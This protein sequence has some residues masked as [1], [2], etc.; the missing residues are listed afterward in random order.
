MQRNFEDVSDTVLLE[1][2]KRR[3]DQKNS[4]LEEMEFLTKKLYVLNEKLKEHDSIKG[5][6]L[7]L[8]KNVFNNPLSSLLNLSS[9]MRK[10]EDS[11]KTQTMKLLLDMELRKLDFQL[12]NI[13]T[14]AE[15]EA[16]EIANY[17]SEID[18]RLII[19]EVKESFA[20]LIEEKELHFSSD[21][22][23]DRLIVSDA[24]KLHTIFA[25]LISNA[26]EYSFATH[27]VRISARI[28]EDQLLI[29]IANTGDVI[30]KDPNKELFSRFKK[31]GVHENKARTSIDG[32]GLGLSI[33]NAL[34]ESLDGE[35]TY[36]SN[37]NLTQFNLRLKLQDTSKAEALMSESANEFMFDDTQ[38]MKEF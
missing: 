38:E 5:E 35:I 29:S 24:K 32:L 25:N 3:F 16:G 17:W 13:F 2:V 26:C 7:S 31:V 22:E 4:T 33:V 30:I 1:E 14:A 23:L 20:Y 8:I 9:M 19:E 37:E 21:I 34:V 6:F 10:N 15:I 28:E 18:L 12:N 27:N 11:P 36:S